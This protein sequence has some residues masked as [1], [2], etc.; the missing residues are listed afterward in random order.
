[1]TRE[2]LDEP[3]GF[4]QTLIEPLVVA[5]LMDLSGLTPS[6][7]P[8]DTSRCLTN[9]LAQFLLKGASEC[10]LLRRVDA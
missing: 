9:L 3:V 5:S 2:K 8:S 7:W 4:R 6:F 1:M 10:C